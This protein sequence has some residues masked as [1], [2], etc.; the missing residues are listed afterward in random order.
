MI[1]SVAPA[2]ESMLVTM[3]RVAMAPGCKGSTNDQT[4]PAKVPTP[5]GVALMTETPV[6]SVSV[7]CT[8]VAA[9]FALVVLV[10]LTVQTTSSPTSAVAIK[11]EAETMAAPPDAYL[12][13]KVNNSAEIAQLDTM[14]SE[15]EAQLGHISD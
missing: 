4:P 5:D 8:L 10:T 12:V 1:K 7:I 3:V 15:H 6:G 14:I 13:P 2:A 11:Y 9:V